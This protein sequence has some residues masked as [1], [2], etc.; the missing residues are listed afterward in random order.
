MAFEEN[1]PDFDTLVAMCQ[2]D[3]N[4]YEAYRHRLLR[5][6]VDN[7]PEEHRPELEK[8]LVRIEDARDDAATPEEAARVAF[9]MM[10]ASVQ[11]LDRGWKRAHYAIAGVQTDLAILRAR[12]P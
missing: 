10:S 5:E 2:K 3:P 1:L 9:D 11:N 4:A 7:A 6:A 12:Q 8:L